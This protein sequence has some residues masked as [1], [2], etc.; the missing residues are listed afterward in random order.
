MPAH[1]TAIRSGTGYSVA[2]LHRRLHRIGVGDVGA[3]E[4]RA[5]AQLARPAPRPRSS[6]R[7][8]I[9]HVGA[10]RVQASRRR[11]AETRGAA[12]D[13]RAATSDLHGAGTLLAGGPA[14]RAN[15]SS[16]SVYQRFQRAGRRRRSRP[17]R[18]A[19][20]NLAL[21]SV[22]SSSPAAKSTRRPRSATSTRA[23]ALG[24]QAH[25]DPLVRAVVERDVLE[26]L[27][28]RSRR[29]ARG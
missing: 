14:T 27:G 13:E 20:V 24:A 6:F 15:S 5:L 26:R 21:I 29:R 1:E 17:R 23:R 11:L 9:T 19:R 10:A 25:L 2:V 18:A 8:A 28:R 3:H 7:S 22:R 12:R 16:G 4:P